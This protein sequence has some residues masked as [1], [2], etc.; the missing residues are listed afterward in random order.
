LYLISFPNENPIGEFALMIDK[1]KQGYTFGI[2]G[3]KASSGY[4]RELI[5]KYAT[6]WE[7]YRK[8]ESPP[9]L[10]KKKQ[11]EKEAAQEGISV[12]DLKKYLDTR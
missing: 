6:E 12:E 10:V 11:V 2:D 3:D 7:K 8:A 1:T 4:Y 5:I 9:V